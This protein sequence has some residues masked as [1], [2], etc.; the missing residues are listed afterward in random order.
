MNG[1]GNQNRNTTGLRNEPELDTENLP[2]FC[3]V[4]ASLHA[5]ASSASLDH[6]TRHDHSQ[7]PEF[8]S[9]HLPSTK[10]SLP[11]LP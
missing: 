2:V 7:L 6:R 10:A 1:L 8:T 3:L 11:S 9:Y 4:S 5:S